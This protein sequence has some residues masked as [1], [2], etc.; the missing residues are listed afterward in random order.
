MGLGHFRRSLMIAKT[1]AAAPVD[2]NVLL[3]AGAQE[4]QRF[5]IP[6]GV[7]CVTL[8]AIHKEADGTYG[9]RRL[10][11]DFEQLI[12]IRSSIIAG[13]VRS[14]APDVLIVDN[15]A[16]G[17]GRE[18]DPVLAEL[19]SELRT[20]VVLGLR[21]ITDSA[22]TVRASWRESQTLEAMRDFYHEIW[23]YGDATVYDRTDADGMPRDLDAR[24]HFVGYF[25]HR[26]CFSPAESERARSRQPN[27]VCLLGGGQDGRVLAEAFSQVALPTGYRG[28]LVSGPF[29][30]ADALPRLTQVISD[31][32]DLQLFQFHP[33][34]RLLV[35]DADVVIGMGGYNTV[36]EILSF[37]KRALVVP[38]E[39]P[40]V[41]QL[42]RAERMEALGLLQVLRQAALS[43]DYLTDRIQR[44]VAAAPPATEKIDLGALER[45]T[46]RVVDL[47]EMQPTTGP[48][49]AA[50]RR[51][52]Q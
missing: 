5:E 20:R 29:F 47:T 1:L 32:D 25:D 39:T 6:R 10:R 37:G 41:E 30:P 17:A 8:P 7:D 13:A 33:E 21:D 22:E 48:L 14:F 27:V 4:A 31:R 19:R 44:L 51:L 18:L 3:I 35:R 40:R 11:V 50:A 43:P 49:P 42:I 2:A 9:S 23:I 38:R 16:R 36:C 12:R 45:I 28:V 52:T 46:E 26:K 15:V 34:P 24:T